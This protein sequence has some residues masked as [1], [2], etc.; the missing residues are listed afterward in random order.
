MFGARRFRLPISRTVFFVMSPTRPQTS[1][2]QN[3]KTRNRTFAK[4]MPRKL[5]NLSP[6]DGGPLGGLGESSQT[7]HP[8]TS[9]N[10][11]SFGI[12]K[13]SSRSTRN[14]NSRQS[15]L[16]ESVTKKEAPKLK[17]TIASQQQVDE[18]ESKPGPSHPE[19]SPSSMSSMET[20][21]PK[22]GR[23]AE[24]PRKSNT[25]VIDLCEDRPE[26]SPTRN[27]TDD[28]ELSFRGSDEDERKSGNRVK[29]FLNKMSSTPFSASSSQGALSSRTQSTQSTFR[30]SNRESDG[31]GTTAGSNTAKS[32]KLSKVNQRKSVV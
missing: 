4:I 20:R 31:V 22:K 11:T 27:R 18:A 12:S 13:I 19:S 5:P 24:G 1:Y 10:K 16:S 7:G 8:E 30:E 23:A 9:S 17:S 32:L 3:G 28:D 29:D 15:T 2:R 25:K 6:F 14:T 26:E 21:I